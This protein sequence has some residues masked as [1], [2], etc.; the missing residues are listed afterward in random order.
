VSCSAGN[1]RLAPLTFF[2][3]GNGCPQGVRGAES[4]VPRGRRLWRQ[5]AGCALTVV[6]LDVLAE[7][8]YAGGHRPFRRHRG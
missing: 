8:R 4:P 6:T 3:T 7:R 1:I 5:L 2:C